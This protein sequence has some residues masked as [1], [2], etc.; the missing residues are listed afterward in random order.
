MLDIKD[1]KQSFGRNV[2]PCRCDFIKKC[3]SSEWQWYIHKW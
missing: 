3:K 2:H 1:S